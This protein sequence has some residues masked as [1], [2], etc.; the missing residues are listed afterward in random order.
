VALIDRADLEAWIITVLESRK[1]ATA[2]T[3]HHALARLFSWL[4]AEGE[5]DRSPMQRMETPKVPENPPTV[6][7][8]EDMRRILAVCKA[9]EFV[10]RR[11]AAIMRVLV[12]VTATQRTTTTPLQ[13]FQYQVD[14]TLTRVNGHPVTRSQDTS[15]GLPVD[16]LEQ[17]DARR[18]ELLEAGKRRKAELARS[19]STRRNLAKGGP[20]W[21]ARVR[22]C[23]TPGDLPTRNTINA[24]RGANRCCVREFRGRI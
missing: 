8:I 11:D 10:E 7:S 14:A 1:P 17:D 4:V 15:N 13:T 24:S 23:G 22:V 5:L 20:F 16:W 12:E 21:I 2:A 18:R 19:R 3:R 9:T 6:L